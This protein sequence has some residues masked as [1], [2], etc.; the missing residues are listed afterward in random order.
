MASKCGLLLLAAALF[1]AAAAGT[2]QQ[3]TRAE[4]TVLDRP[5]DAGV[6]KPQYRVAQAK[7]FTLVSVF[8]GQKPTGGYSVV[9]TGVERLSGTC[10]VRY[11]V[12]EPGPDAIVTQVLTYPAATVRISPACRNAKVD[13]PLPR[14]K[15]K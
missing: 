14:G 3:A 12:E 7:G 1:I 8:A 13:P 5:V 10:T 11:H 15:T 6:A 2:T 9:V 4:Y